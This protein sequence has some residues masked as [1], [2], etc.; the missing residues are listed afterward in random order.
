MKRLCF[1]ILLT[2]FPRQVLALPNMIRLGYPTC[3]SCHFNPQGG[4]MLNE[5]GKGIDEAQ[6]LR[7]GEY[8]PNPNKFVKAISWGG[9]IDQDMKGVLSLQ[10]SHTTG[11]PTTAIDRYRLS[12]RNVTRLAKSVRVSAV[13]DG[14]TESANRKPTDYDPVNPSRSFAVRS[15]LVEF[16]PKEGIDLVAGLDALPTGLNI[17]DQTTFIKARNRLSYYDTHPMTKA[18][19]WGKR[20]QVIPYVFSPNINA[21][22]GA[23]ENGGGMLAEYDLLGQGRTVVGISELRGSDSRG[24]RNVASAYARLGFGKWGVLAE[25]D[26]TDRDLET[27]VTN[28]R[29]RQHTTY[30][31]VFL[32]PREWLSVSGIVERLSVAQ[33]YEERVWAYKGDLAMRLSANWSI[34]ARSGIQRNA[35]TGEVS[36]VMSV[37]LAAKWVN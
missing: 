9:R 16:L 25:H 17:P 35:L 24:H 37:Q 32:Y 2:C 15:A 26:L 30:A 19:F 27:A 23:R 10:L 20:W 36:P 6:S 1:L 4:G 31:Q 5:Y 28:V 18:F 8:Q 34:G 21:S 13:I 33:P 22:A 12:Y 11:G 14:E 7:G 3:V 29:F